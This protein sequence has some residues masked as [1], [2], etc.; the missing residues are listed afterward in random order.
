MTKC[1]ILIQGCR[2]LQPDMTISGTC[3]VAI[4]KTMICKIGPEAELAQEYEHCLILRASCPL[5]TWVDVEDAWK[6]YRE[7]DADSLVTVKSV[8][9]RIW[10]VQGDTLE[11][12][13]RDDGE[14]A[15][16]LESRALIILRSAAFLRAVHAGR[17]AVMGKTIPY[18][19]NDRAIEIQ[20]Y[21]DWWIC[22]RLL[23]RRHVESVH[24]TALHQTLEFQHFSI[25]HRA[26]NAS[27]SESDRSPHIH[28]KH[29]NHAVQ[30]L[31]D[32]PPCVPHHT[33][34]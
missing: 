16:V 19:L 8:R 2:V 28:S 33:H 31:P 22:E 14:Q 27:G 9:Q 18:F 4:D 11:N 24:R 1:D 20:G 30:N 17:T 12:L 25:P 10:N 21:Q 5:M 6:R 23:L 26:L 3:S 32:E 13:L 29:R 15:L 7:A 34:M